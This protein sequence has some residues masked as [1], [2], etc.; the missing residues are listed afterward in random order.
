MRRPIRVV[1]IIINKN[2]I[3]LIHRKKAGKEYYVFPGGGVEDEEINEQALLREISEE[4]SVKVKVGKLLYKHVYETSNQYYYLCTYI[5][6]TPE[7]RKDSIEKKRDSSGYDKYELLWVSVNK[8][9][10][11]LIYP[12]EIRDWLIKDIKDN[13]QKVP[14]EA[15]LK[16]GE[17]RQS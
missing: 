5:S 6:G 4:T 17:L 8:L 11:L 15:S 7:L 10:Q 14:K 16:A 12:L 2:G 1:G 13:F 3:L 9:P